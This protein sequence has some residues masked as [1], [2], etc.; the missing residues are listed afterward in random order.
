MKI[1]S[2]V[3]S[4][5]EKV[6]GKASVSLAFGDPVETQ[7]KTVIPVARVAYGFGAGGSFLSK[8][9]VPAFLRT[10]ES[11]DQ[12]HEASGEGGGAG[13]GVSVEPIGVLEITKGETKYIPIEQNQLKRIAITLVAGMVLSKVISSLISNR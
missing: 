5:A 7:E 4:L 12:S 10:G 11:E 2:V 6:Q 8:L 3:Q 13:G 1:K 9:K